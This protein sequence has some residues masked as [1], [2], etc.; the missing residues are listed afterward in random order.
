M[1]KREFDSVWD[2]RVEVFAAREWEQE[3]SCEEGCFCST[4]S[5]TSSGGDG[6]ESYEKESDEV[7][8]AGVVGVSQRTCQAKLL[9]VCSQGAVSFFSTFF[10]C[11]LVESV[12]S[13][14]SLPVVC[15]KDVMV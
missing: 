3:A 13:Y 7:I 5:G 2:G 1:E 9:G 8:S 4:E 12:K 15:M 14:G 11:S 6:K 10:F